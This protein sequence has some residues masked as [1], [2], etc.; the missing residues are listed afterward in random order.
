MYKPNT[1][2]KDPLW[3]EVGK[4]IAYPSIIFFWVLVFAREKLEFG[5]FWYSASYY[6][7]QV[8][9]LVAIP[10]AISTLKFGLSSIENPPRFWRE[11]G[12]LVDPK[13]DEYYDLFE[14]FSLKYYSC[15]N[16]QNRLSDAF[17]YL[18][19]VFDSVAIVI[20][21][22]IYWQFSYQEDNIIDLISFIPQIFLSTYFIISVPFY[23]LCKVITN[24]YP[25][26]AMKARR[27][28]SASLLDGY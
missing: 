25:G 12:Y 6:L 2:K 19:L 3:I 24:R 9:S 15:Q 1:D 7:L 22:L 10:F 26:E 14:E 18:G 4:I 20:T 21:G 5:S 11:R 16:I 23:L 13:S 8:I 17:H 27:L 28:D